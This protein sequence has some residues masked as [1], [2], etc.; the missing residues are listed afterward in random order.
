MSR[1][2]A[3]LL[4]GPHGGL[5]S[6]QVRFLFAGLLLLAA[7]LRFRGLDWDDGQHLHPDERFISMVEDKITAPGSVAEYFDSAR[8]P[9]NP[10]NKGEGSFVYGTF[11]LFLTKAVS[12]AI[13]LPG[14]GGAYK[15]GR[16]LSGVFDLLTV[17][18]VYRLA[19]R[20]TG[21][22]PSLVASGLFAFSP[23]AIQSSHFWT[24]ETF[25]AAL[26]TLTLLGCVRMAQGRSTP[27]QDLATG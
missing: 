17:W 7:F 11:P 6:R 27:S 1:F 22:G 24:V 3:R 9:L 21:R 2:G 20:F 15:V 10:Y 23:L 18:L 13:G 5:S 26:S 16:A 8:S 14:Y 25:L 12:H 19:R 4:S